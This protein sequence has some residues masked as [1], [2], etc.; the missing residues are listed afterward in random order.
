MSRLFIERTRPTLLLLAVALLGSACVGRGS[1]GVH[2]DTV[3]ADIVFGA[4]AAENGDVPPPDAGGYAAG[5]DGSVPGVPQSVIPFRNQVPARFANLAFAL[6]PDQ[7]GACPAAPLGA[8][9]EQEAPARPSVAPAA[10]AY[11]WVI[12]GSRTYTINGVTLPPSPVSGFQPRLVR[13]IEITRYGPANPFDGSGLP[14][15]VDPVGDPPPDTQPTQWDFELVAPYGDGGTSITA[16]NVNATPLGA[17]VSPPYVGENPVRASQPEGGIT[18]VSITYFDPLGNQLGSFDPVQPVMVLPLPALAGESWRSV[19]I[20]PS[21]QTLQV[22]GEVLRRQAVDACGSY[23]DGYL[24]TLDIVEAS[25]FG[26]GARA[27]EMVFATQLG[28]IPVSHRIQQ[29]TLT[30][31]GQIADDVTYSVGQA[32]PSPLPAGAEA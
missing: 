32:Q 14:S 15:P 18:I 4:P 28:G 8:G 9:V 21:G 3:Q 6:S 16:Y 2:V 7:V 26:S 10:G 23:V 13:N 19:G 5:Q 12:S 30:A 1:P 20:D 25:S 17:S 29:V 11:R 24:A 22:T 27:E 31:A